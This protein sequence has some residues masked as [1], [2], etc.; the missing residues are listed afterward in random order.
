M[1]DV[2]QI[3]MI[4]LKLFKTVF[5]FKLVIIGL[6]IVG[7]GF[8]V[9]RIPGWFGSQN[10]LSDFSLVELI[11][12]FNNL[13]IINSNKYIG[14]NDSRIP[15]TFEYPRN[16]KVIINLTLNRECCV[17]NITLVSPLEDFRIYIDFFLRYNPYYKDISNFVRNPE[18]KGDP[19]TEILITIDPRGFYSLVNTSFAEPL[20][21]S[22]LGG[23]ERPKLASN[24]VY[25]LTSA[26]L[27][28][29]QKQS[30]YQ[31]RGEQASENII[32]GKQNPELLKV[33]TLRV[34]YQVVNN[35]PELAWAVN[36]SVLTRILSSIQ[37]LA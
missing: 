13:E 27:I 14:F 36:Q 8:V 19:F 16:W 6:V 30:V 32:L 17:E 18:L 31:Q 34:N 21:I 5:R 26:P 15:F 12:R 1:I 29:G 23:A 7:I 3:V 37:L 9:W 35:S 2:K 20:L 25:Q 11:S 22:Q 33:L 10:N 28:L 4:F 24:R